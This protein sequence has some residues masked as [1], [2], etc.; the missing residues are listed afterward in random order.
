M[1]VGSHPN[2]TTSP[3]AV[4]WGDSEEETTA[5]ASVEMRS[6][7]GQLA[8][9]PRGRKRRRSSSPSPVVPPATDRVDLVAT[10]ITLLLKSRRI[11]M[12]RDSQ[13]KAWVS[14]GVPWPASCLLRCSDDLLIEVK[15]EHTRTR[16][17]VEAGSCELENGDACFP[18]RLDNAQISELIRRGRSTGIIHWAR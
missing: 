7:G 16:G 18:I 8:D 3:I 15:H 14:Q 2:M 11:T 4:S 10:S 9:E 1:H 6:S 17:L 5:A 12:T 13:R